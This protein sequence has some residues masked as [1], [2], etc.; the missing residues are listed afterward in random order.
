M[1]NPAVRHIKLGQLEGRRFKTLGD[2]GESIAESLLHAHGFSDIVNLN[3]VRQNFPFADF[4]A[5][6]DGVGYLINVKARNKYETSGKLNVRYKLGSKVYTHI[7]QLLENPKYKVYVPAWLAIAIEAETY[8][9]YFGTIADLNGSRG[10]GMGVRSKKRWQEMAQNQS[11]AY[12]QRM[13]L[14]TYEQKQS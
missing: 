8:D 3:E 14:N 2:I 10:I 7:N 12:D 6:R 4:E 13:F 11:H 1:Y 5:T 9:A